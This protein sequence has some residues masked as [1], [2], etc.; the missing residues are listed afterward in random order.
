MLF[1][2]ADAQFLDRDQVRSMYFSLSFLNAHFPVKGGLLQS[3][4]GKRA[5]AVKH[6]NGVRITLPIAIQGVV[7]WNRA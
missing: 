7:T 4:G 6:S 5:E 2:G 3:L 1:A